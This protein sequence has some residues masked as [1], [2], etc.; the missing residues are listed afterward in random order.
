M[1]RFAFSARTKKS[2]FQAREEWI[3]CPIV[4]RKLMESFEILA[5]SV[6]NILEEFSIVQR[7]VN[8][9]T[10]K[11]AF[12]AREEIQALLYPVL[13]ASPAGRSEEV[14]VSGKRQARTPLPEAATPKDATTA[15]LLSGLR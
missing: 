9:A 11:E 14:S 3:A 4:E 6:L 10:L 13:N 7:P 5:G 1:E 8:A 12:F 2:I 15:G